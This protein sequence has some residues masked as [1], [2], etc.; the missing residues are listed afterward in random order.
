MKAVILLTLLGTTFAFGLKPQRVAKAGLKSVSS[1]LPPAASSTALYAEAVDVVAAKEEP[2]GGFLSSIWNDQTQLFT[3]LSVWYLG[4]IYCKYPLIHRYYP[5]RPFPHPQV[6]VLARVSAP[7]Y[8]C[9]PTLHI[10]TT[11]TRNVRPGMS[12]I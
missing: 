7:M 1:A 2:K 8:T 10:Y 3:Y 6:R 12:E 4:N 11:N 9:A 5:I